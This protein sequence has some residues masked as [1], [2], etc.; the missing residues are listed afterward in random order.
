MT[1]RALVVGYGNA[2]RTDDGLGWHAA[3]SLLADPRLD[4]VTVLQRYQLTP[5]LALDV[6]VATVVVLVDATSEAPAGSLTVARVDR[7]EGSATTWSHHLDPPTLV[8]LAA[9]LYG[10]APEVFLVSCGIASSDAG[11]VLS[12]TV[13]AALTEVVDKVVALVTPVSGNEAAERRRGPDNA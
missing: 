4:G 10:S 12:A 6:S 7:S 2:L 11:D 5:E 8:A 3:A 9:E 13:Q 1:A